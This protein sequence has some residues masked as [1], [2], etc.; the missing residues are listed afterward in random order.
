MSLTESHSGAEAPRARADLQLGSLSR[1]QRYPVGTE[2][3]ASGLTQLNVAHA[4]R[5]QGWEL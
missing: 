4:F 1:R 2:Q 3:R 5:E